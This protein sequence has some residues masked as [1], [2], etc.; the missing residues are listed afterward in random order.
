MTDNRKTTDW[1]QS[2]VRIVKAGQLDLN[3]RQ[4]LGMTRAA[5]IAL[6]IA[7]A[8]PPEEV[9]WVDDIHPAG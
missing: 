2:G 4:T 9:Q 8:E 7:P 6:D 3:T 5:A 1:K